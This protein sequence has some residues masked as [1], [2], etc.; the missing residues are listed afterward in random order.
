MAGIGEEAN[1][2]QG[3]NGWIRLLGLIAAISTITK[4]S[5][6]FKRLRW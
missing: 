1:V 4:F 3:L 5:G 6:D 2:Q